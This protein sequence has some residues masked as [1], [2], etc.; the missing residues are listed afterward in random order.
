MRSKNQPTPRS[1]ILPLTLLLFSFFLRILL[2][3]K[4]PYHLDCLTLTVNAQR[5]LTEHQLHYQ[6][7]SGYPLTVLTGS[8]FIGLSKILSIDDPV[9]AVN[10]MSV[11]LSSLSVLIF[12]LFLRNI[13]NEQAA[14]FGSLA[15]SLHPVFLT[16]SVYGNSHII[17]LFFLL[18]GL[19]ILTKNENPQPSFAFGIC[20][21][22]MGAARIQ[23][24]ILMMLPAAII[25]RQQPAK[26]LIKC[27]LLAI[28]IA[29][30][31]HVPFLLSAEHAQYQSQLTTFWHLGL[32]TNFT[33]LLSPYLKRSLNIIAFSTTYV[34]TFIAGYGLLKILKTQRRVGIFLLAWFVV[35]LLFYGNVMTTVPRFL[36]ISIIP[37]VIAEGYGFSLLWKTKHLIRTIIVALVFIVMLSLP[38]VT[39]ILP[40]LQFRH[41]HELLPDWA[42]FI[43]KN[44]EPDAVLI[45]GD[46]ELFIHTYGHRKTLTKRLDDTVFKKQLSELLDKDIPVYITNTGLSV[47]DPG[48]GLAAYIDKTYRLELRGQQ[49]TEDWHGG[50]LQLET[51]PDRLYRLYKN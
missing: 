31:F 48:P 12:F 8:F 49:L 37:L 34:G 1:W 47:A 51:I 45:V 25:L 40:I 14:F 22:L 2:I 30:G 29:I 5:T 17:S 9:F 33:G 39:N 20:L 23:D 21:G 13:L 42:R 50:E 46:E 3:N 11:W 41:T 6:F 15:L 36:L 10:L 38:L 27:F 16:L 32:T 7:G 4:G 18:L 24:M 28:L 19:Y 26:N 44:T 43:A 35:P